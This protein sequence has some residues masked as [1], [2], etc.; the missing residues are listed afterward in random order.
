MIDYLC[1]FKLKTY[2]Y[3]LVVLELKY[4]RNIFRL[5]LGKYCLFSL[6]HCNLHVDVKE[7]KKGPVVW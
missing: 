2:Y 1:L 7:L 3:K 4:V 6:L 5:C